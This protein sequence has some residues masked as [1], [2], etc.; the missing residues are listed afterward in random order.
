L[1]SIL[2]E[3]SS[4]RKWTINASGFEAFFLSFRFCNCKVFHICEH[5]IKVK[6]Y[7]FVSMKSP[8]IEKSLDER[9]DSTVLTFRAHTRK[10]CG[11]SDLKVTN[12]NDTHVL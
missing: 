2:E 3:W 8:T 6:G 7:K 12:N 1:Y 4:A 11:K 9:G 5:K 10:E